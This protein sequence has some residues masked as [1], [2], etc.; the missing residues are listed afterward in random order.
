M[1]AFSTVVGIGFFLQ[2]GRVTYLVGPGLAWV[3]YI[4]MGTAL[5]SVMASL[6][7]MTALL[8][9][10]GGVFEFPCRFLD[11]GIGYACGWMSWYAKNQINH[12]CKPLV[13]FLQVCLGCAPR[14]GGHS[15]S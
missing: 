14:C 9:V 1:I 15:H 12:S 8:P 10:K 2:A 11:A 5:W 4:L 6:G 7:E 3:A 13:D